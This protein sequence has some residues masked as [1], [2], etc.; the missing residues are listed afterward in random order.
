MSPKIQTTTGK[1]VSSYPEGRIT[2]PV[3]QSSEPHIL[4]NWS[5]SWLYSHVSSASLGAKQVCGSNPKVDLKSSIYYGTHSAR[6]NPRLFGCHTPSHPLETSGSKCIHPSTRH[7]TRRKTLRS[8]DMNAWDTVYAS[9]LLMTYAC[10]WSLLIECLCHF[11]LAMGRN[12]D[13]WQTSLRRL[14]D[15]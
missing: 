3:K 12:F 1:G 2:L 10:L 11:S 4:I 13:S 8:T 7:G 15:R 14:L 6:Y 9:P 5:C